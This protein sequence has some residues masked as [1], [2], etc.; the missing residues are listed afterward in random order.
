M[1]RVGWSWRE[2]AFLAPFPLLARTDSP[3]SPV[4]FSVKLES[5]E[6]FLGV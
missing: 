3:R 6:I 4:I 1:N 5:I 2:G